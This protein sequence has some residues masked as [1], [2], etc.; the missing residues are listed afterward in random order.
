MLCVTNPTSATPGFCMALCMAIMMLIIRDRNQ[1]PMLPAAC[2]SALLCPVAASP[3][4]V[5]MID[6]LKLFL[7]GTAQFGLGLIFL[8]IGGQIVC[9][10]DRGLVNDWRRRWLFDG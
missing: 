7:F 5:S 10:R 4:D 6:L 1:T 2:L 3:L 8:T 9:A